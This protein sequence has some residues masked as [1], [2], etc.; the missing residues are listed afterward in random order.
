M[1][2]LG[3]NRDDVRY[4]SGIL[5]W[6]DHFVRRIPD[7]AATSTTGNSSINS[8]NTGTNIGLGGVAG[9]TARVDAQAASGYNAHP[10]SIFQFYY[11][12]KQDTTLDS[13]KN[14]GH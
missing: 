2:N 8:D 14:R 9:D 6:E 11:Q 1:M 7:V 5:G 12:T 10:R 13:F 4:Q 3:A